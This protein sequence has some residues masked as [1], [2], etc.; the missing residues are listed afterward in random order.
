MGSAAGVPAKSPRK[1]ASRKAPKAVDSPWSRSSEPD[2]DRGAKLDAVLHT[3]ARMFNEK[4][5]HATSLDEVAEHLQITKPTLYYYV[6]SKD[7]ILFQCVSRGLELMKVAIREAGSRGASSRDKLFAAMRQ[8][9]LIV[10]AD[11]GMCVIRV[12]EDPLPPESRRQLRKMKGAIDLEFRELIRQGVADGTF[13]ECDP[14]LAAFTIAG[15]LSWIGR[16]YR[17]DGDQSPEQ[18][19]DQMIDLLVAGLCRDGAPADRR[20]RRDRQARPGPAKKQSTS[21]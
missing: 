14:K 13:N 17:P 4:G 3:A 10:T 12:G 7:D 8:Y 9:A 11:F 18:I 16:W 20:G 5:F 19:A 15:A 21:R 1:T 6:R 2:A